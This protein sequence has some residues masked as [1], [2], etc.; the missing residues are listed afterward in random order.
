MNNRDIPPSM[1]LPSQNPEQLLNLLEAV[2]NDAQTTQRSLADRVGVA[3]GLANALVRRAVRKGLI[4]VSQA[5][6]R[7][8]G[9]YLTP[10]G[11]AEKS[12]LVAEYLH[13]SLSFFRKARGEYAELFEYC[14]KRGWHRVL[15]AGSGELAEIALISA[16]EAGVAITGIIDMKTNRERIYGLPVLREP[17]PGAA[18]IIV[19]TETR[20]PHALYMALAAQSPVQQIVAPKLLRLPHTTNPR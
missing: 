7:R 2:E 18:E 13:F 16:A 11:F 1:K 12:H 4:K 9:Y 19:M 6:V 15:L 5:P 20:D 10:S 14:A 17:V 8:Y 3:L